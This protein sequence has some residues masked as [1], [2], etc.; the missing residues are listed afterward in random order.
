MPEL[1]FEVEG[2]EV[3]RYAATPLLKF[4]L[5]VSSGFAG[6]E[7]ANVALH[8][9][10]YIEAARRRYDTVEQE[11][12]LELF[13]EPQRFGQTVKTMLWT[14]TSVLIPAFQGS[15]TVD[16]PVPCSFD[17]NVV[18]TKYF[19]A[20]ESGEVPLSF[21]FSGSVFY[22]DE[23]AALQV[24][25]IAWNKEASFRLPVNTWQEMMD[26]YYPNSAWLRLNR[27]VFDRLYQYKMRNGITTWEQALESLLEAPAENMS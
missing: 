21:Q 15:C 4:K 8:C 9:K 22:R 6:E 20:L 19:N 5:R 26:H 13:G 24:G 25:Q 27:D 18:A 17:F 1:D 7:I 3:A 2:A 11:G 23:N 16:L 14:H 10:V 12:L